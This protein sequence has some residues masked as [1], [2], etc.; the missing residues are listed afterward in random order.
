MKLQENRAPGQRESHPIHP[1][2]DA[3]PAMNPTGGTPADVDGASSIQKA[4]R[5]ALEMSERLRQ[6]PVSTCLSSH[7]LGKSRSGPTLKE[8]GSGGWLTGTASCMLQAAPCP[9]ANPIL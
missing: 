4:K 6:L 5:G 2:K 8:H 1:S 7:L 9:Q 3:V